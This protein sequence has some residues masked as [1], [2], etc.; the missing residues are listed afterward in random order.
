MQ[1]LVLLRLADKSPQTVRNAKAS[2]S[3][4]VPRKQMHEGLKAASVKNR[5][6]RLHAEIEAAPLLH[7]I[8]SRLLL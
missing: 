8:S 5:L 2:V 7:N 4:I 3:I 1:A 6:P